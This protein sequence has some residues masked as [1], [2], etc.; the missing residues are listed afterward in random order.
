MMKYYFTD[1]TGKMEG[2][3]DTIV[4]LRLMAFEYIENRIKKGEW[5]GVVVYDYRHHVV[6]FLRGYKNPLGK[7]ATTHSDMWYEFEEYKG[8]PTTK[9]RLHPITGRKITEAK[10]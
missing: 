2:S 8:M 9:Y 4:G 6:G 5:H 10:R 3:A 1:K 7:Y